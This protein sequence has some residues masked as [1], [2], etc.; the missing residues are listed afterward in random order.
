MLFFLGCILRVQS[1]VCRRAPLVSYLSLPRG[2]H[3]GKNSRNSFKRASPRGGDGA[4]KFPPVDDA[5][6]TSPGSGGGNGGDDPTK[7]N[8]K[9]W[10]KSKND[11]VPS[12]IDRRKQGS[13]EVRLDGS[14]EVRLEEHPR[15]TK[16]RDRKTAAARAEKGDRED[17]QHKL[18]KGAGKNEMVV[19]NEM[20][21]S[22]RIANT[23]EKREGYGLNEK[24]TVCLL[25]VVITNAGP[26][27]YCGCVSM[28]R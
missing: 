12:A 2:M 15:K 7:S 3:I 13:I 6:T 23:S 22:H 27:K 5:K 25:P 16:E 14:I 9:K 1:Y 28:I 24:R 4:S 17:G 18:A 21:A 26:N 19:E 20:H 11:E 8:K 10:R